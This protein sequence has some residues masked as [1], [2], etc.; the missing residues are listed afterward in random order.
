ML[1]LFFCT[2]HCVEHKTTKGSVPLV[3]PFCK[4]GAS[5]PNFPTIRW[6][7]K[8]DEHETS[9]C[10]FKSDRVFKVKLVD[11][12]FT[13]V[14]EASK[15]FSNNLSIIPHQKSTTFIDNW[16]IL[17]S[18]NLVIVQK[19]HIMLWIFALINTKYSQFIA[20]QI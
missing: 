10:F 13:E 4:S 20:K 14:I 12:I 9:I 11:S 3:G 17:D 18:I 7:T 16:M 6:R 15:A 5:S 8:V 2:P 19:K 1:K